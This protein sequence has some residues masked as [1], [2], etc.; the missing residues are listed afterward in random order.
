MSLNSWSFT[1]ST[2]GPP[3]GA[4][5]YTEDTESGEGFVSAETSW[6]KLVYMID[7]SQLL[8]FLDA[9]MGTS[10]YVNESGGGETGYAI[11]RTL[12]EIHPQFNNFYCMEAPFK[13]YG[14]STTVT[15]NNPLGQSRKAGRWIFDRVTATFRPPNYS[16]L[17]DASVPN[18]GTNEYLGGELVRFCTRT[19]HY[20]VSTLTT[21]ALMQ[22]VQRTTNKTLDSAPG[23][24]VTYLEK[25]IVWC[26]VPARTFNYSQW[27]PPNSAIV[28]SVGGCLNQT[29]FDGHPA[30]TVLFAGWNPV[31][32]KPILSSGQY[33][34]DIAYRFVVQD[35]GSQSIPLSFASLSVTKTSTTV[36]GF[37]STTGITVGDNVTVRAGSNV[38]TTTVATV[39]GSSIT[40]AAPWTFAD[41]TSATLI[42]NSQTAKGPDGNLLNAGPNFIFDTA[43]ERWDLIT[44]NGASNGNTLYKFGELNNLFDIN[45]S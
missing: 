27:E 2:T 16:V 17:P 15:Q 26:Q 12:P 45:P 11:T 29:T 10:T 9:V 38:L 3:Y 37:G 13:R 5:S 19:Y 28:Q 18:W 41:S 32:R 43:N 34:W 39:G 33:S 22:F 40:L 24:A 4:L 44:N 20:V 25:E 23:Y 7:D 14:K 36:S 30:G 21:Q 8:A 35:Q 42:D 6:E 31:L 1:S